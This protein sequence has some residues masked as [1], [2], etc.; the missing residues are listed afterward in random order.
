MGDLVTIERMK[1]PGEFG[2]P[3][4]ASSA[5]IPVHGPRQM[6]TEQRERVSNA[7]RANHLRK[8]PLADVGGGPWRVLTEGML[9]SGEV[10]CPA[11]VHNTIRAAE[12]RIGA[13]RGAPRCICP[14]A[15]ALAEAR[16]IGQREKRAQ[17]RLSPVVPGRHESTWAAVDAQIYRAEYYRN[18]TPATVPDLSKGLCRWPS[19]MK[20]MDAAAGVTAK[21]E[22]RNW[23]TVRAA[24]ALCHGCPVRQ[25]CLADVTRR[26]TP[27]GSWGG[28]FGG[29]SAHERLQ[30]SEGRGQ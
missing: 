1:E 11:T 21:S 23:A 19:G 12:G 8:N 10:V 20:V 15:L 14:R 16:V 17:R 2:K 5:R 30:R 22:E 26:E 7:M 29:L 28:V 9:R 27:A 25:E 4:P 24:K 3:R 13:S 6:T 18:I